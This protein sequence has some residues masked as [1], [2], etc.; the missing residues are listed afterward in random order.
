[1]QVLFFLLLDNVSLPSNT[2][3]ADIS[4]NSVKGFFA[5]FY[6][7]H[8]CLPKEKHLSHYNVVCSTCACFD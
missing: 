6:D 7:C 8:I 4:H 2:V 1:M 5:T 3:T